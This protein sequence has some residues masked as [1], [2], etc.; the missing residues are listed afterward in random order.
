[1]KQWRKSHRNI[2]TQHLRIPDIIDIDII[3]VPQCIVLGG[4]VAGY[5][6]DVWY[7]HG[8]EMLSV[9]PQPHGN[10]PQQ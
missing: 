4:L 6:D 2:S 5:Q 3:F 10:P 1:M 9:L 8:P 7:Y